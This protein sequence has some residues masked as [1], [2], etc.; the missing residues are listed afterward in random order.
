MFGEEA[1]ELLGTIADLLRETNG[2][3]SRIENQLANERT[4]IMATLQDIQNE[5]TAESTVD[6]GL[7]T[8]INTLV[9]NQNNPAALSAILTSMQANIAP[10]SAALTANTPA[11]PAMPVPVPPIASPAPVPNAPASA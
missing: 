9:A 2:R 3:L 5:V 6:A 10:L 4:L 1:V 11:A 7:L 8:L